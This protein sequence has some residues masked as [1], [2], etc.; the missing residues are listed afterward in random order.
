MNPTRDEVLFDQHLHAALRHAPDAASQPAAAL[1]ETVLLAARAAARAHGAKARS[2]SPPSWRD[3]VLSWW[4]RPIAA[5]A[6]A[7]LA[8]STVVVSLWRHEPIPDAAPKAEPTSAA[9]AHSVGPASSSSAPAPASPPAVAAPIDLRADAARATAASPTIRE[10]SPA[11]VRSDRARNGSRGE[12]PSA[13]KAAES[14][15]APATSVG[16][17]RPAAAR[18]ELPTPVETRAAAPAA[19]PAPDPLPSV[20]SRAAARVAAAPAPMVA[21][22]SVGRSAGRASEQASTVAHVDLP[23]PLQHIVR[24]E[25][26]SG[27]ATTA[28]TANAPSQRSEREQAWVSKL[29]SLTR[30]RWRPEPR[31]VDQL[32]KASS[33][34]AIELR[35][36]GALV[37]HVI[38]GATEVRVIT[39]DGTQ[40]VAAIGP[41]AV[42]ELGRP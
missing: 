37:A 22:D 36:N 40:W 28:A 33:P 25:R 19:A 1:D 31:Q 41:Q 34:D 24:S 7:A 38:V 4:R 20:A 32:L 42:G 27:E 21:G 26:P 35:A 14:A 8:L 5:P 11:P 30:G 39:P 16:D 2:A 15:A 17:Q 29:A 9:P 23:P 6:F 18:E 13:A 12:H 3:R 10:S